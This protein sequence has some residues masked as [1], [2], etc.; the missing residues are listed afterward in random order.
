MG[1]SQLYSHHLVCGKESL[2]ADMHVHHSKIWSYGMLIQTILK[3]SVATL[4]SEVGR[5]PR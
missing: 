5:N 4:N 1:R 2:E 3:V